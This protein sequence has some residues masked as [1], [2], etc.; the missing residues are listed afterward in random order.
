MKYPD[1]ADKNNGGLD[2]IVAMLARLAGMIPYFP[3]IIA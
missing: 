3:S 2:K 1:V